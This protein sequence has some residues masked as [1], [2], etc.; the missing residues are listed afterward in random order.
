MNIQSYLSSPRLALVL[1]FLIF[2]W[3]PVFAQS[4]SK[5]SAA[6]KPAASPGAQS[7]SAPDANRDLELDFI[8][9]RGVVV[10][11]ERGS[12]GQASIEIVNRDAQPIDI[13]GI[14]HT[15]ERFTAQ[16]ET[17]EPGQRYRLTVTFTASGPEGKVAEPLYLIS[18]RDRI[19]IPVHTAVIPR[20]Y[21]FPAAVQMGK[22]PLSHI[23]GNPETA[24]SVAQILMVYRKNTT[25]FEVKVSSDIPFLNIESEQG[26]ES[27]RW[28]NT[29][30]LDPE[31]VQAGEI[32]GTIVIETNDP[33]VPKLEVPVSGIILDK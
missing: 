22:F 25:G 14:E 2:N 9:F 23:R 31:R 26:P 33:E 6:D 30:W 4:D 7:Q 18:N 29:I 3:L 27:D 21:T 5:S 13:S 16:V 24:R 12:T 32:K 17:I 1:A 28:E 11:T 15:S 10:A 20:V 8:P 19:T